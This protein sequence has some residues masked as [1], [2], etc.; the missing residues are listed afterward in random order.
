MY[1]RFRSLLAALS[2]IVVVTVSLSSVW[3]SQAQAAQTVV[4]K[5]T[6]GLLFEAFSNPSK[7]SEIEVFIDD[8]FVVH[9]PSGDVGWDVVKGSIQSVAD[10]IPDITYK[11]LI[12]V[13]EGSYVGLR[14][15]FA[16]TFT[17]PM[18]D[19]AT[20]NV[21]QPTGK[22]VILY[23]NAILTF[24][25]DGKI[26]EY[27]EIFDN[28]NFSAQLGLFP[29]PEGSIPPST[30]ALDTAVWTIAQTSPDF[31]ATLK[32]VL[33]AAN[34]AAYGKGEVDALDVVYAPDFVS[35]PTLTDLASTKSEIEAMRTAVPDLTVTTDVV[36]AEGNWVVYHW[37]VTG[38]FTGEANFG[39][40]TL[41]PT[42][43]AVSFDG[44]ALAYANDKGQVVAEWSEID[45]LSV[46]MQ[47]GMFPT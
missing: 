47:F 33:E 37:T 18:S 20:G 22:P 45:N 6:A 29:V 39:G 23:S 16:G 43:Q 41:V 9:F 7:I 35:Y 26:K 42:H 1:T 36:M 28:L 32:D 40:M 10:A 11:P 13:A 2:A 17:N 12:M 24:S 15:E 8:D 4:N 27:S 38:T 14:Y 34:M 21:V 5:T 19:L 25:D 3:V 44:I 30:E 46:G 31:T